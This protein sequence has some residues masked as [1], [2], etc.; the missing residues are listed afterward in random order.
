VEDHE[1]AIR[2]RRLD[3]R[4]S[5][6]GPLPAR[7]DPRRTPTGIRKALPATSH[8]ARQDADRSARRAWLRL[9]APCALLAT[10]TWGHAAEPLPVFVSLLLQ[11]S[12]SPGASAA[13]R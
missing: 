10:G 7:I 11:K 4:A 2:V 3:R 6:S 5:R 13:T 8:G 1:R 12:R 9:L